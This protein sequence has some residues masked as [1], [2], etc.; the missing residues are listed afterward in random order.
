MPKLQLII[1]FDGRETRVSGPMD[2]KLLCYG[3]L[4]VATDIIREFD[5]EEATKKVKIADGAGLPGLPPGLL[6]P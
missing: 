4:G 5:V 2:N 6:R 3:L 1:E